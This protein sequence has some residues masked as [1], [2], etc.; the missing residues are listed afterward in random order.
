M[1]LPSSSMSIDANELSTWTLPLFEM[2]LETT[3]IPVGSL[4]PSASSQCPAKLPE[5]PAGGLT[6]E[7]CPALP[8]DRMGAGSFPGQPEPISRTTGTSASRT[9]THPDG[10]GRFPGPLQH[11]PSAGAVE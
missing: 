11:I 6:P 9:R 8:E 4:S 7:D 3:S 2:S 1:I 10:A 5:V